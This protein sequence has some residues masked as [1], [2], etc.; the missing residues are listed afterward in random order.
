MDLFLKLC[1]WKLSPKPSKIAI[2]GYRD[3]II[4]KIKG[5]LNS[6]S[7]ITRIDRFLTMIF[8]EISIYHL[9][10]FCISIWQHLDCLLPGAEK[11]YLTL[12]PSLFSHLL[13]IVHLTSHSDSALIPLI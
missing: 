3:N 2:F 12:S 11:L 5:P 9:P 6:E 13:F 4:S 1:S 8:L 7:T 10:N